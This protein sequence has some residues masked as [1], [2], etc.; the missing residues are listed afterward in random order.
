VHF[1]G[2]GKALR[3]GNQRWLKRYQWFAE[4]VDELIERRPGQPLDG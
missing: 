3:T 2:A 1:A 4:I